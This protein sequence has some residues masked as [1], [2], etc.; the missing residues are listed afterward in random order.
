MEKH[1]PDSVS[2]VET[3]WIAISKITFDDNN[4]NVMNKSQKESLDKV[5]KKYGYAKDPWLNE[6]KDGTY[7]RLGH[8]DLQK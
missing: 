5:I 6:N 8:N 4:P 3:K 2:F 7:L 1:T